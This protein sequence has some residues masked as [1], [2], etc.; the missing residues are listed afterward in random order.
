MTSVK[1]KSF[2]G[3][4]V[5]NALLFR[6]AREKSEIDK[7]HSM[8]EEERK[9]YL[10]LNPKIVTNKVIYASFKHQVLI[11]Q[12]RPPKESTSSCKSTS[13]EVHSIWIKRMMC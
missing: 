7:I 10:R 3:H 6:L 11:F 9:E 1:R 8:T 13:T 2:K 5:N 12:F 4:V